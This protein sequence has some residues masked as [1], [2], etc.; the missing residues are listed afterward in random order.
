M[1]D[2]LEL[3]YYNIITVAVFMLLFLM[4]ERPVKADPVFKARELS[5]NVMKVKDHR[6]HYFPEYERNDWGY[7]LG[8]TWNLDAFNENA[9]WDNYVAFNTADSAVKHI[10]WEY[11]VGYRLVKG[12]DL[13]YY[14]LSEHKAE[15][16]SPT[17]Q[18][19]PLKNYVGLKID[20]LG[21]D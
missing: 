11:T 14:H 8:L 19:Y 4:C 18:R 21:G 15:A 2:K 10:Y 13:V 7:H 9:Y 1:K 3:I 17:K 16:E 5:L 20:L 12:L 6:D